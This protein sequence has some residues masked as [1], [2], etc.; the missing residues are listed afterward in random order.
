MNEEERKRQDAAD[1]KRARELELKKA[2]EICACCSDCSDFPCDGAL[3]EGKCEHVPC[4]CDDEG[5][6]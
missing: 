6:E 4:F 3:D 2:S 5:V 1:Q